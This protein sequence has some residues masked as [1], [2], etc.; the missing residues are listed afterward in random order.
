METKDVDTKDVDTEESSKPE[1]ASLPIELLWEIVNYLGYVDT[2]RLTSVSRR[3]NTDI[4][5]QEKPAEQ[6]AA[7]IY[8]AQ[9]WQRHNIFASNWDRDNT[10][11]LFV[12]S[13]GF[14]CYGCFKV[15]D[16]S[17]F[18]RN[19]TERKRYKCGWY[20][21]RRWIDC[22]LRDGVYRP[23]TRIDVVEGCV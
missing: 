10:K 21:R 12:V 15:L 13:N 3:F 19:Q 4:D 16:R 22:C 9:F 6:K 14:A 23:G 17:M 5:P 20:D 8:D 2:V 11:K 1:L 18:A 7:E